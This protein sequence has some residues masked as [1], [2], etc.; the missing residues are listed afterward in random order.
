MEKK[1]TLVLFN[2]GGTLLLNTDQVMQRLFRALKK[3]GIELTNKIFRIAYS[4]WDQP[5]AEKILPAL[6][7]EEEWSD[8]LMADIKLNCHSVFG[9]VN[10]CSPADIDKKL[11]KLKETGY[12]L[13]IITSKHQENFSKALVN[14]G[15]EEN[16]FSYVRTGDDGGKKISQDVMDQIFKDNLI[17]KVIFVGDNPEEIPHFKNQEVVFM[18]ITSL[19]YFRGIFKVKGVADNL[20]YDSLNEL[21]DNLAEKKD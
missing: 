21:I 17:Q 19:V 13:G 2:L 20:I 14:I 7:K 9:N 6:Q 15:L 12:L 1:K 16:I 3:S 8:D 5:I 18:A 11:S 10:C 4:L